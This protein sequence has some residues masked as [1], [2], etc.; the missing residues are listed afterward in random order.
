MRIYTSNLYGNDIER[1]KELGMGIMISS[2]PSGW[3]PTK[4]YKGLPCALDNGAFRCWQK[5]YPFMDKF[6]WATLEKCYQLDL[7]LDFIVC[8]DLVSRGIESLNFSL[9]YAAERLVGCPRLALAVQDGMTPNYLEDAT[10]DVGFSHIFVGGSLAWKWRTAGEWVQFA[11]DHNLK[12]HIGRC[13]TMGSLDKA[14]SL[15]VDSVDSAN[16]VRNNSFDVVGE[17]VNSGAAPLWGSGNRIAGGPEIGA[18]VHRKE[19]DVGAE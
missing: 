10:G 7:D 8:P 1:A 13:G 19:T 9:R 4:D 2:T 15:G 16:F 18:I 11:R 3:K 17:F 5:G 14:E 6:F 12:C